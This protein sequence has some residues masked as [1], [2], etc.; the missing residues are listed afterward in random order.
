[1]PAIWL[2]SSL[3]R[4]FPLA[5]ARARTRLD[6]PPVARGETVSFQVCVRPAGEAAAP[7]AVA[8]IP[9]RP[10][11]A[12]IRRAGCVPVPHHNADTPEDVFDGRLP[13]FV[14]D[15]LFPESETTVP[16]L[17]TIAFW[18]TVRIPPDAKPGRYMLNVRVVSGKARR[19]LAV[20]LNVAPVVIRPRRSFRVT[21]W[22]WPDA[23]CDRW[24]APF[25]SPRFWDVTTRCFEN[26]AQH[27]SDTIY[28][29]AFTPALHEP[30][31]PTQ[32]LGIRKQGGRY[33]FDWRH[34][35]RWVAAAKSS[36][37]T[38]FEWCHLVSQWGAKKA[39]VVT[40]G[41]DGKQLPCWPAGTRATAPAYRT[42]LAQ[43]LP[44][45]R[46]FLVAEGI[47]RKSFF[48]ISDEPSGEET[49]QRYAKFRG[50][51]RQ[52]APWMRVM[53]ALSHL[54]F[55][56]KGLVDIPVAITNTAPQFRKAGIKHWAY[57]CTWPRGRHTNRFMDT[58]LSAI[59]M[60]GALLYRLQAEGFLHWGYNYW[61]R[62]T[63][64]DLI[65]PFTVSD[66]DFWPNFGHGD[67]FMVYP[68]KDGPLDSIRWE[69]FAEGL[70][71]YALL[72]TLGVSSHDPILKPLRAYDDFPRTPTWIAGVRSRLLS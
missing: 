54:E 3:V 56:T 7:V 40:H 43:W 9:P 45:L 5:P 27:G 28:V 4:V 72:E 60:T 15:P 52:L 63:G 24:N 51:L 37:I 16:A 68:G 53:D 47:D 30:R 20:R 69:A 32:L 34:V 12:A 39:P 1:M 67:P 36:G 26:L 31:R 42:F 22:F 29:P 6:L 19:D 58:P 57:Y 66:S 11:T 50:M 35:R 14:P 64:Q 21:H 13:G 55:A 70:Q 33:V 71:D 38:H 2:E 48:H 46:R 41:R 59:R 65:D 17:Q 25:L 8:L 44:E 49:M 18:V 62:K 61:Y 10:L 23:I